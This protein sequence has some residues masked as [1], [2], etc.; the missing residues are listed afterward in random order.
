MRP[1]FTA[2]AAFGLDNI[3]KTSWNGYMIES[4]A[5][6][7]HTL[8]DEILPPAFDYAQR[9]RIGD[10]N[11]KHLKQL[12]LYENQDE[13]SLDLIMGMLVAGALFTFTKH[14]G[15]FL[16]GR[17]DELSDDALK[18]A[19]VWRKIP[20]IFMAADIE[21]REGN[22]PFFQMKAHGAQPSSLPS[23]EP[24]PEFT[25][26]S[27]ALRDLH[28]QGYVRFFS[29][30][31]KAG[32]CWHS[33]G[34]IIPL[35]QL[36]SM[37]DLRYYGEISAKERKNGQITGARKE[38]EYPL[39]TRMAS[40]PIPWIRLIQLS[41]MPRVENPR[42]TMGMF[43]SCAD[44]PKTP[45]DTHQLLTEAEHI[46]AVL[47]EQNLHPHVRSAEIPGL[48]PAVRLG[49]EN[50]QR[51][52]DMSTL[53]IH[54]GTVFLRSLALES[55]N[56]IRKF[57]ETLVQL[58]EQP[59]LDINYVLY[60]YA[61]DWYAS[62]DTLHLL[63][64][65]FEDEIDDDDDFDDFDNFEDHDGEKAHSSPGGDAPE[66]QFNVD[67]ET[68]NSISGELISARN[69]GREPDLDQIMQR[70]G[71]SRSDVENVQ[72]MIER[73]LA[74]MGVDDS[75]GPFDLP[76]AA[77]HALTT[78]PLE[79][80]DGL[81]SLKTLSRLDPEEFTDTPVIRVYKK[82]TEAS[83][84]GGFI[85]ATAAGYIKPAIVKQLAQELPESR[86]FGKAMK[87]SKETDW[88]WLHRM[89]NVFVSAGILVTEPKGFRISRTGTNSEALKEIHLQVLKTLFHHHPW[90]DHPRF[91][92]NNETWIHRTSALLLYGLK[93]LAQQDPEQRVYDHQMAFHLA[94]YIPEYREA[95]KNATDQDADSFDSPL[96]YLR[97]RVISLFFSHFCVP[98]GL[99][100]EVNTEEGLFK[101]EPL[102][103]TALLDALVSLRN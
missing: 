54:K 9:K 71:A 83:E 66:L 6:Y 84:S 20:W 50:P 95:L 70:T 100:Q 49:I 72:R 90:E 7:A 29:L 37:N 13:Q 57:L 48:G 55:Y 69:S 81:L 94:N 33:Y 74:N 23:D 92:A 68:I 36:Q 2:D 65:A 34:P 102:V 73:S 56:E 16:R 39:S 88:L 96:W 80:A 27:P 15:G 5:R 44:H 97:L 77:V 99:A 19:R 38:S 86:V 32:D 75:P 26:Y 43:A 60:G 4:D 76:P 3:S 47:E 41:G 93:Y 51:P 59:M 40:N 28:S 31:W 24:W 14:V 62:T 35:T 17:G 45:E 101:P 21:S 79:E 103:P 42:F 53:Y 82:L 87:I 64:E 98:M 10:R 67:L 30:F 52:G 63:I 91:S 11:F 12:D 61:D 89:R 78:P 25:L 85:P 58:P 1:Q 46:S 18:T 8:L 22:T